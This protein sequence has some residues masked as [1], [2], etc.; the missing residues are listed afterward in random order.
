MYAFSEISYWPDGAQAAL[1]AKTLDHVAE[2]LQSPQSGVQQSTCL[3]VGRLAKHKSTAMA[4]LGLKPCPQLVG[5]LRDQPVEVIEAAMYALDDISSWPDGV[6]AALEAKILDHVA[7][8]LESPQSGVQQWTCGMVG[9]FA[10]HESTA[11]AVLGLKPCPQLIAF[12][13][14]GAQAALEAKT[15]DHVMELLQSPQS[16]V[17]QQTCWMVG[18]FARYESTAMAVLG[19]KPC[20][21]L[22]GLLHDQPVEVIKAAMYALYEISSWPDGAQAALEAKT[23]DHVAELLESPQSGVRKWTCWTVGR[24]ARHESTAVAVLGLK[25]CPQLVGLLHD[26]PVEVIKAA[27]YALYEIS[28]WPDGAQAALEAKTLDHV[29]ELLESPQSEVRQWTCW[30][31]GSCGHPGVETLSQLVGLLH[32]Q[33]VEVI[34]AA[35]YALYEISSWP[36]GAQ[37]ALEAKTLDHVVELLESP[38]SEVRNGHAG[39]W[40]AVAILGLKPCPQLVGLLHDQPVEVIKA[41]MYALYEISSWPDG[42]QAALEAKTLDHV[43]ELLESPQSEVRQWTCW[44]VGRFAKHESTAVAV[45]GLKPCPQLVGLLRDQPV[46]VIEATMYALSEI[47]SWPDGV[48]A[49]LEAKTLDH[50]VE[51]LESPQSEVRQWT[52]WTV[53]RFAKH[54]STAVAILG[55]KPCPQLV[56]LLRDQPAEV[57]EAT[58]YALSEIS[59]WPDGVQAALE[60]KHSTMLW[61]CFNLLSLGSGNRHAG[62]WEATMYALSE[63]SSWPDDAQ[64]ALE[65]KTLDYVTELLQSPQSEVRK[66]TCWTV[67]RFAKHESTAMAVLGLKPCP[68]LVGLLRDQPV[69]VIEATMYALYEISSWSDGA[70]AA[71]EAKTLDHVAELLESPQSG[72]QQWTHWMVGRFTKHKST[73]VAVLELNIEELIV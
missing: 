66:W 55:L 71:L 56:G 64:A 37:A 67:G 21:Q 35:M 68:Q 2:L 24:F 44:T 65:A 28:S 1:E 32:D 48:Q 42:A 70:Q 40:E 3:M 52:C 36:D 41:A 10:R 69:E 29:V 17:Q 54:E 39:Q 23:L 4:V 6:Q 62:W 27:M 20:P 38:Q 43:V 73:A 49:A 26:Q 58:M 63:I 25:P 15:L 53:G 50:V 14:D 19:L 11:M 7:E 51:L 59:S 16:G 5:L 8:L 22:V 57:I 46:E 60:A 9:S 12:W 30:T 34:K 13:P 61:N 47:S 18:S 45:L 33:P 31:V 72:V